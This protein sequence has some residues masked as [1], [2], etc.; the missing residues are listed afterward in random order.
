MKKPHE[1]IPEHWTG[2]E[3]LLVAAFLEDLLDALADRH[4]AAMTH[5]LH[6]KDWLTSHQ[7]A[8]IRLGP[9]LR[10]DDQLP[11]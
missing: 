4:R 10:E 8:D 9:R 2:A 11:F 7:L 1:L 5:E 3:A 6:R